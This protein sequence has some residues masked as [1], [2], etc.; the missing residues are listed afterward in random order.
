MRING[1]PFV[2]AALL[3]V[4]AAGSAGAQALPPGITPSPNNPPTR[5]GTRGANFLEIPVGA[6]ESAMA[7]A[8]SG[9]VS[10]PVSWYWNPAGAAG[11]DQFSATATLQNLYQDLGINEDYFGIALPALGGVVGAS[12]LTLNSGDI[13]RTTEQSPYG[14]PVVGKTFSWSSSAIGLGYARRLT[15]RLDVGA[16]LK[17]ISEGINDASASWVGVDVGTQFR[18]GIYGL[19]IG[20]ALANIGPN[21][22]FDGSLLRRRVT[23][24][25]LTNGLTRV[26]YTTQDLELPTM[27]RFSVGEDLFGHVGSILGQGSGKHGLTGELTFDHA[28]DTDVQFAGGLEYSFANTIF[29]R[30]G[31]R[32]YNDDRQIGGTAHMYGVSAGGGVRLPIGSRSLRF[33]YAYTSLGDLQNVQVFTFGF[34]R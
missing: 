10:G 2:M 5:Q 11:V 30:A 33:D 3:G 34:G 19:V 23:S 12:F 31:K 24:Q 32:F 17:F 21:S 25:Q 1:L 18:T 20:A 15:D 28:I 14:D 8:V 9:T 26:N 22:H 13:P 29:L 6:R 16:G 7:G 27:F 4:V